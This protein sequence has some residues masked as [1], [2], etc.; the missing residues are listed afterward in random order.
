MTHPGEQ[1]QFDVKVVPRDCIAAPEHKFYQYTAIDEFSRYR[2]LETYD[3]H[4]TSS[5]TD[6]LRNRRAQVCQTGH[7]GRV[8]T[9]E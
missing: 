8:C 7:P 9:D 5:S 4:S 1:I 2:V 3:E 6:F